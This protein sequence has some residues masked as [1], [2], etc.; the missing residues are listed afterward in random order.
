M[1]NEACLLC[2]H[3]SI[4]RYREDYE[5][6]AD[7]IYE[8]ADELEKKIRDI[9]GEHNDIFSVGVGIKCNYYA[10]IIS[11]QPMRFR[12]TNKRNGDES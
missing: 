11:A 10:P 9:I 5:Y 4:C 7:D 12:M 6:L 2:S 1:K 8:H 3:K